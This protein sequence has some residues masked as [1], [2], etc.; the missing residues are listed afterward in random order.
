MAAEV[1]PDLG[2]GETWGFTLHP[3]QISGPNS[4][5]GS[6]M[7]EPRSR[8]LGSCLASGC[9]PGNNAFLISRDTFKFHP[10]QNSFHTLAKDNL[11][12]SPG[13]KCFCLGVLFSLSRA[14]WELGPFVLFTLLPLFSFTYAVNIGVPTMC[15]ALF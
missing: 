9:L 6:G 12:I 10:T 7:P 11:C 2:I 15:Q 8:Q 5:Q 13:W 3:S 14:G 4:V 1:I